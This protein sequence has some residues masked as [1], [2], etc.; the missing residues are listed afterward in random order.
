MLF[1]AILSSFVSKNILLVCNFKVLHRK[2]DFSVLYL[3]VLHLKIFFLVPYF[4]VLH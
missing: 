2:G 4:K 1:S 3:N